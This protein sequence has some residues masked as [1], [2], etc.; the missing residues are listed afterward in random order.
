MRRIDALLFVLCLIFSCASL[1]K[2]LSQD[3]FLR[4]ADAYYYAVQAKYVATTGKV[5]IPDSSPVHRLTGA[6]QRTGLSNEQAV[7]FWI[8]SS[9]FL[10]GL[11]AWGLARLGARS[12]LLSFF[13]LVGVLLSP[14]ALFTAIEFPK[15]FSW[16]LF[17][18]LW[19]YPLVLSKKRW[20]LSIL[21][22]LGSCL[23]HRAGIPIAVAFSTALIFISYRARSDHRVGE[24]RNWKG[25][26]VSLSIGLI[27]VFVYFFIFKDRFHLFDL[28]RLS[29]RHLNLG[30]FSLLSRENLPVAIKVELIL[31]PLVF[32]WVA[33]RFWRSP[34][35]NRREI[36]LP[37]AIILPA[38]FP[39]GS[40]EVF[41]AGER[42]AILLPTLLWIG[43][44]FLST[45]MESSR[46]RTWKSLIPWALVLGAIPFLSPLRLEL[47]HP[48]NLDPDYPGYDQVVK[49]LEKFDIPMLIAQKNLVYFYDN[50]LSREAFPYEPEDHWNKERVWR[51]LYKIFPEELNY[52]LEDRCKWQG[53]LLKSLSVPDYAL[54]R[55][56]CWVTLRS[57]ITFEENS[58]LYH[59]AWETWLN[60]SKK[61]PLFLYPKHGG[62]EGEFPALPSV[63]IF[64]SSRGGD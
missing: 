8:V 41:N 64:P 38:F 42:Y 51:L 10:F 5:R 27:F 2:T 28:A 59:R 21:I 29:W 52:Y 26:V 63:P 9:L 15:I 61:R 49:E 22:A 11:S 13:V 54:I 45:R 19:F 3:R 58:D 40:E 24:T 31:L 56:D 35:V 62:G 17:I 50:R 25:F 43:S 18:P 4:G 48:L 44:L 12:H 46:E 14:S 32:A 37:C 47:S 39:M 57:K 23:L 16:V 6:F 55:E 60:P 53:G 30:F 1:F 36:F 7:R 34:G 33:R 20:G